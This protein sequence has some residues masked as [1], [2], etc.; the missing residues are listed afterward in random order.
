MPELI[1][2]PELAARLDELVRL[3]RARRAPAREIETL[4]LAARAISAGGAERPPE[5]ARLLTGNIPTWWA[6]PEVRGLVVSL[7]GRQTVDKALEQIRGQVGD[8]A[9]SRSS[10][11]RVWQRLSRAAGAPSRRIR[12]A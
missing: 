5:E 10:M 3:R 7:H 6:D 12:T 11:H 2:V 9:P 8:R 1:T 4:E